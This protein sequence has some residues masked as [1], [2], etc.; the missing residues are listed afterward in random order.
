MEGDRFLERCKELSLTARVA[1][2][3]LIFEGYC[4]SETIGSS[5]LEE[6]LDYMWEWPR[7]E[8]EEWEARKPQLVNAGLGE[9][10]PPSLVSRLEQRGI[11]AH[12]FA[13]AIGGLVEILWGS[14]WG[15][16]EDNGSLK[17]L[18]CVVAHAHSGPL[19][20]LTPF[21]FSRFVDGNGWGIG[22]TEEDHQYWQSL[23]PK[24]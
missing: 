15:A 24:A 8:F 18:E 10:L 23:R 7:V 14:F 20:P 11:G 21:R 3:L 16:A 12:G 17:A 9:P 6:F 13:K 1:A 2:A 4:R 19:P 22:L 5:E